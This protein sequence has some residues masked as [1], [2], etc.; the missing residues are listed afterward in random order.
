MCSI[1][2][3]LI[4]GSSTI[5]LKG[6]S[7]HEALDRNI[8][9]IYV[10][11]LLWV[12]LYSSPDG[13]CIDSPGGTAA[14]QTDTDSYPAPHTPPPLTSIFLSL[15]WWATVGHCG[16]VVSHHCNRHTVLP[17]HGY[18][19]CVLHLGGKLLSNV[20]CTQSNHCPSPPLPHVVACAVQNTKLFICTVSIHIMYC[21]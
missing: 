3:S 12:A 13:P 7:K 18:H 9:H 2:G 17:V 14:T 21:M 11:T 15:S 5:H 16:N 10:D 8:R 20:D 1:H 6:K 4:A 19:G